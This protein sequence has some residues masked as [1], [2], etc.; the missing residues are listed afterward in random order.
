MTH[1]HVAQFVFQ[2]IK[3][4]KK[5]PRL[6]KHNVISI[7]NVSN[8]GYVRTIPVRIV[9]KLL[10]CLQIEQLGIIL[11]ATNRYYVVLVKLKMCLQ[12]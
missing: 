8:G 3:S 11:R 12:R 6:V 2:S 10:L 7:P 5:F 1:Q 9:D 4:I